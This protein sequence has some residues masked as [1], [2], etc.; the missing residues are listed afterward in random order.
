MRTICLSNEKNLDAK[1]GFELNRRKSKYR[2]VDAD[3]NVPVNCRILKSTVETE[4]DLLLKQFDDLSDAILRNDSEIDM[5]QAGRKLPDLQKVYL[6]GEGK[7]VKSVTLTEHFYAVDGTEKGSRPAVASPANIAVETMP[8][9][10]TGKSFPKEEAIRRF[11]FVRTYQLRHVSGPTFRFLFEMAS[12]LAES[13]SM[14]LLGGGA[15]GSD[16]LILFNNGTSYRA[17][18]EGRVRGDSYVLLMHL[19]NLELKEIPHE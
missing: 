12:K 10:W 11:V 8:V 4:P 6:D 13:N 2:F 3:G 5:E 15:D 17:F 1:V 19:A 14:M 16:P 18:L 7:P 9:R